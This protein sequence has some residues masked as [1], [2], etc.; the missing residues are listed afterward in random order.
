MKL[1]FSPKPV[2]YIVRPLVPAAPADVAPPDRYA[3]AFLIFLCLNFVLFV[4]P[5]ELIPDEDLYGLEIYLYIILACLAVGFPTVLEQLRLNILEMRPITLCVFGFLLAM[6]LS[7]LAVFN[8][9]TGVTLGFAYSKTVLY[10]LLFTG[11]ITTTSRLRNVMGVVLWSTIILAALSVLQFHDFI[12]L[13]TVEA[14]TDSDDRGAEPGIIRLRGAGI[15]HDPND[16][17]IILAMAVPLGLARLLDS[18]RS[19]LRLFWLGPLTLLVYAIQMTRSRGGFLA[20]LVGVGFV[21]VMRYGKR[22]WLLLVLVIPALLVLG[23]SRQTAISTGSG[24]A[25]E[26]IQVWADALEKIKRSPLFGVGMNEFTRD[27]RLV[28]HNSYLHVFAELG[29]F[30]GTFFL[31]ACFLSLR[32]LLRRRADRA[33]VTDP[34]MRRF[35]PYVGGMCAAY[36]AGMMSLS[37]A[38]LVPTVMFLAVGDVTARLAP[39]DPPAPEDRVDGRLLRTLCVV[40]FAFLAAMYVFV[41]VSFVRV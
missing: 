34:E 8:V 32:Q 15:V 24:T 37:L 39:T 7:H 1:T 17:C 30:G 25:Q 23:G 31:G 14:L 41:R 28:A 26:R 10:Y 35:V 33:V 40:S 16:F 38:Y 21:V 11:L 6:M 4:R 2:R 12:S 29:V 27:S 9:V 13:P 36:F 19:S 20:L 5:M 18:T 3:I 22:A